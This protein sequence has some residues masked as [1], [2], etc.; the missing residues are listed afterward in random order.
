M[1]LDIFRFLSAMPH[2]SFL[3]K[4]ELDLV[5]SKAELVHLPKGHQVSIQG[6]TRIENVLVIMKGQLSLYHD[7]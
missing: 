2:F 7:E 4:D 6:Q 3:T 1:K 5:V